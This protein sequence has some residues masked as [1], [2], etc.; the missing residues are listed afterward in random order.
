MKTVGAAPGFNSRWWNDE[1]KEAAK[2]MRGGFLDRGRIETSQ[3]APQKG[4]TRS[5]AQLGQHVMFFLLYCANHMDYH[6]D[7]HLY[8]VITLHIMHRL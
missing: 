7:H 1:C 6:W 4:R 2:A 3:Q 5:Q 8:F